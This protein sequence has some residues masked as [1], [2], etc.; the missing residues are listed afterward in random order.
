MFQQLLQGL[1]FLALFLHFL[2]PIFLS[3]LEDPLG[4]L[5]FGLKQLLGL[6]RRDLFGHWFLI[7]VLHHSRSLNPLL[8]LQFHLGKRPRHLLFIVLNVLEDL[9]LVSEVRRDKSFFLK[10][11]LMIVAHQ[12][13]VE[14]VVLQVK[15]LHHGRLHL[16]D[17]YVN[18]SHL[19]S[20]ES[21]VDK[22]KRNS[23]IV[24]KGNDQRVLGFVFIEQLETRADGVYTRKYSLQFVT[25]EKQLEVL[26]PHFLSNPNR[27]TVEN[28]IPA[29]DL[30][31]GEKVVIELLEGLG[32]ELLVVLE[33]P[34]LLD[35][36]EV[37]RDLVPRD[38]YSLVVS[39]GLY[40]D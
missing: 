4:P 16:V 14:V 37:A 7:E 26:L 31:L 29:A 38:R 18:Q 22:G 24:P 15:Q 2:L 10:E 40:S 23:L 30:K 20:V 36:V 32:V 17:P 39:P 28:A 9:H 19:P 27:F 21:P 5:S 34:L 12:L 25:L 3:S 8:F 35:F 13:L 1:E 6:L 33:N 11:S